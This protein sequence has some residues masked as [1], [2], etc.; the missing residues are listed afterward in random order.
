MADLIPVGLGAA[1]RLID[2]AAKR[3]S[4]DRQPGAVIVSSLTRRFLSIV[5]SVA[6]FTPLSESDPGWQA[7]DPTPRRYG[8]PR[9]ASS[10]DRDEA[11]QWRNRL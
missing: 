11:T 10:P 7:A 5:I 2:D 3:R 8:P 9:R 1:E 6:G 4:P